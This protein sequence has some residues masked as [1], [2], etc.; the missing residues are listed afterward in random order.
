MEVIDDTFNS[1]EAL[2]G[3]AAKHIYAPLCPGNEVFYNNPSHKPGRLPEINGL[4]KQK[5]NS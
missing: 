5:L 1:M 4:I 3:I 2:V